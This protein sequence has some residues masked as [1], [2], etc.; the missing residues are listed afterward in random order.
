MND[1]RRKLCLLL[2]KCGLIVRL[3]GQGRA[4]DAFAGVGDFTG[5][6]TDLLKDVTAAGDVRLTALFG[7]EK[8][9]KPLQTI[10]L[11]MGTMDTASLKNAMNTGMIPLLEEAAGIVEDSTAIP[12]ASRSDSSE[13][14]RLGMSA[15]RDL[16]AGFEAMAK[17]ASE[18]GRKDNDLWSEQEATEWAAG[19]D[20][21]GKPR[22]VCMFGNADGKCAAALRN[23]LAEGSLLIIYEPERTNIIDFREELQLKLDY[24]RQE[25]LLIVEH[26]LYKAYF[27]H[28]YAVFIRAINENRTRVMVN[29][30]TLARFR[31]DA[32]RNVIRNLPM[33]EHANLVGELSRILPVDVPV[34][35]VS[36]GPS[37]DRNIEELRRA[38]GHALIFAV[39]TAMKYLLAHDIMPDLA[40]TVEPI[41]PMA[42][43]EDP[44]CFVI[45]HVFD[46]ESNP[47]IVGRHA[48]RKF[49][50]NCRDYVKRLLTALGKKV[51]ADSPSGGSVATAAFAICYQL[52]MR[53]IILI[54]QDLAYS[55]ESTHAGGVESKGINNDIGY[56]MIDG[57]DGGK[58][59]SR[60]DW[61]AY[62]K[63]FEN[64]IALMKDSGYDMEVIDATEGGALIHGSKVMTLAQAIDEYCALEY[65]FENELAR[66]PYLLNDR[67]WEKF[68]GLVERSAAE[69]DDVRRTA[70]DAAQLCGETIRKLESAGGN[71]A[72]PGSDVSDIFRQLRRARELCEQALLYPLINN[73]AVTGIAAEVSRLRLEESGDISELK[74]QKL[75]FE[76]I[77]DACMYFN[78]ISVKL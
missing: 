71:D 11:S 38:K 36:A 33:M 76:A 53:R 5:A 16:L 28:E 13:D 37:L 32:P 24:Y 55:G 75:A 47:E 15:A 64:A 22:A 67:E 54:G 70:L 62:L 50:Y 52:Q 56:E 20:Y 10:M 25:S 74:Q 46:N 8:F 6:I 7:S 77:V 14:P 61:L 9:L 39:D 69:L 78:K 27:Q 72:E 17:A 49:I 1:I 40:I 2:G 57:I 66:L 43:Y 35:I 19:I 68:K 65:N 34:I 30:N 41:K 63:W 42:N 44:R 73:Y 12:D 26:P 18:A 23:R 58:V 45:P 48:A 60:S 31:E 51:P 29:R 59:R 21:D 3:C 4:E